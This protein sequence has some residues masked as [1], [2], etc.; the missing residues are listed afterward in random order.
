MS[1]KLTSAD[2]L[3]RTLA[4]NGVK[5]AYGIPGGEV[6]A[7]IDA[8]DRAGIEFILIKHENSGGFMA[9]G[10]WHADGHPPVLVATVGPGVANAVNV[11][12]NAMQDRVPLIFVTGC[13]DTAEAESYTHQ[14][15][16]HRKMLDEI[17]KATFTGA[18]STCGLIAQKAVSIALEPQMGPVHLDIPVSVAEAEATESLTVGPAPVPVV[19][20]VQDAVFGEACIALENAKNPVAITGVDAVNELA[21]Q[22]ITAFCEAHNIPVIATYKAKGLM[23]E[24]NPL[25][26]GGAGLSPKADKIIMPLLA[27]SDCI[28]LI[29]YDPIEMRIGW[30]NPW[31]T[32]KTVIEITPVL[33]T[34]GMHHV[35]HTI[36]SS[37]M[38]ALDAMTAHMKTS[39]N[40]PAKEAA[41]ARE[42]FWNTFKADSVFGPDRVFET[43]R[44]TLP[45][46]TVATADSGAHRI[47]LSQMWPCH[48]PRGMLQS[49]ALCTMAC[50]VPIAA[51]YKQ[52]SPETPVIAFVGD[53]G[54]E[55]GL[56]E[57][58]TLREHKI[59]V[60]I[61]VL[62]DESLTLIEMKQR[63]SQRPN[64]G[65]D[66]TGSDFPTVANA[67]GGHGVWVE[68]AETLKRAA[69][70][71]LSRDTFTL[72]A[73]KI[74]RRSYDGRF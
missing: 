26:I 43:L 5:R 50:A 21:G 9:E 69:K 68:D 11:V 49:S 37:V 41:K 42:D 7:I 71:A 61:C 29:G 20:P 51:G 60:I 27:A 52:A 44:E 4:A 47:L 72:L 62:V 55:M 31:D 14:V 3:A 48:H 22:A 13:V 8:F 38:P 36:R 57:L 1:E 73:C 70:D 34:H 6:L 39:R 15:F 58:A 17:T 18:T 53:A 2:M 63:A 23:D 28:L 65:V 33:R 45:D 24:G 12:A 54:M 56:G 10:G 67:I 35:S 59:P 66:F 16:D 46:T 74:G 64:L 30:R 32:D 25:A 40:T 19:L